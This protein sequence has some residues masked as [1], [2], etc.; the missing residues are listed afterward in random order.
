MPVQVHLKLVRRHKAKNAYT[1]KT[2]RKSGSLFPVSWSKFKLN[3]C[4]IEQVCIYLMEGSCPLHEAGAGDRVAVLLST[5]L[6]RGQARCVREMSAQCSRDWL[7]VFLNVFSILILPGWKSC[8]WEG[9]EAQSPC[10]AM[11]RH[12]SR[13]WVCRP[14]CWWSSAQCAVSWPL[15]RAIWDG[16]WHLIVESCLAGENITVGGM[17]KCPGAGRDAVVAS[18]LF[19][20]T[21]QK[22]QC[23]LLN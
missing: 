4:K 1:S 15:P 20:L 9:L 11:F 6:L 7:H 10:W 13:C 14:C 18:L 8:V 19:S 17:Q 2:G 21:V 16:E 5:H 22:G 12:R 23:L 3:C